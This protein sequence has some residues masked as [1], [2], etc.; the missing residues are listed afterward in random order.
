MRV[1]RDGRVG[2][3]LMNRPKQLNALSGELMGAVVAALEELDAD[4]EIRAIVLGGGQ[5]AFAA[6]ADIG[7][8][9][10]GTPISL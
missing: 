1:E 7:E 3:V 2:V 4:P 5:R 10:A 6:G 9:A 8:L